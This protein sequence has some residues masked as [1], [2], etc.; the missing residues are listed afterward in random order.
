VVV[1][2]AYARGAGEDVKWNAGKLIA[3]L[4]LALALYLV[5]DLVGFFVH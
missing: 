4:V 1:H 2:R 5:L 3:F